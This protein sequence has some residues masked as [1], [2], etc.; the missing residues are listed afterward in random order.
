LLLAAEEFNTFACT[1]PHHPTLC[2]PVL[3]KRMH[4]S[5]YTARLSSCPHLEIWL[6]VAFLQKGVFYS[7]GTSNFQKPPKVSVPTPH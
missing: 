1:S 2:P 4:K 6:G 3:R 7:L 5:G